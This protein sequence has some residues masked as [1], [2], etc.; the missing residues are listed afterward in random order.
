MKL[1]YVSSIELERLK[2]IAPIG[3]LLRSI[4]DESV[5]ISLNNFIIDVDNDD[6]NLKFKSEIIIPYKALM[7]NLKRF[8]F[9]E[10]IEFQLLMKRLNPEIIFGSILRNDKMVINNEDIRF[11]QSEISRRKE[12][13]AV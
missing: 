7:N 6:F 11:Y 13:E 10:S 9:H 1:Y 8:D 12:R 5:E 4:A 3:T 2:K